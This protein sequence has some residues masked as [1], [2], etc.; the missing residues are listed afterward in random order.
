MQLPRL[1][2]RILLLP[3]LP[4]KLPV[5]VPPDTVGSMQAVHGRLTFSKPM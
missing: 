3:V 1:L 4:P 2:L 5:P